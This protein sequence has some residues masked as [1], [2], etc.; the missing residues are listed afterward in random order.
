MD[1]IEPVLGR[2]IA[3]GALINLALMKRLPEAFNN[4]GGV[5]QV[6]HLYAKIAPIY[7][8]EAIRPALHSMSENFGVW[9]GILPK[10]RREVSLLV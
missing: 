4:W 8:E 7:P 10:F 3:D 5:T 9:A 1:C 6:S 2:E